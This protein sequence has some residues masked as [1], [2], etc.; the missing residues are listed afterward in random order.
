MAPVL[1][2]LPAGALFS[3][4][5]IWPIFSTIYISFLE[6]DGIETSRFVGLDNYRQ[7]IGD[8]V[9]RTALVNNLLW[10][11]GFMVAPAMGLAFAIF[12]HRDVPGIGLYRTMFYVPFV[13]SP[14][15]VGV[16]FSWFWNP[17]FGLPAYVAGLLDLGPVAILDDE[18]TA[19]FGV[20][21]AGLWPQTAYCMILFMAGLAA[22]DRDLVEAGRLDGARGWR[23]FHEIVLPQLRPATLIA[24]IVCA[25]SALRSFDL[26]S[27]MTNGGPYNASNVLAYLMYQESF[28]SLRLG[29][30]AAIATVLL[31]MMSVCIALFLHFVF[32]RDGG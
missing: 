10:L 17:E 23:L 13:V 29:Y 14:A 22:L 21:L 28:L 8:A 7:L 16:I 27:I 12:L 1:F 11:A 9:F 32:R 19:I 6:W 2:L 26:V 15:V 30:G 3:C 25:V 18:R 31:L 24:V 4:F 20:I 5:V